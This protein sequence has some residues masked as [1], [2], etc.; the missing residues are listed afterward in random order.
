MQEDRE[1]SNPDKFAEAL[2]L[3]WVRFPPR[4]KRNFLKSFKTGKYGSN[5]LSSRPDQYTPS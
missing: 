2:L 3:L 4:S 1:D 5:F